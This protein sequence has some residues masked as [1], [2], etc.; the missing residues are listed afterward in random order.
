MQELRT[1]IILEEDDVMLVYCKSEGA[2]DIFS[3]R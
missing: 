2:T 1:A 3:K